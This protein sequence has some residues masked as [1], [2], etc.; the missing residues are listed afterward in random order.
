LCNDL[1]KHFS[2][3]KRGEIR[4]VDRVSFQASGGEILGLLGV[5]GAGKTTTLRVLSTMLKPTS[6]D[7]TLCGFSV[8]N[9]PNE[10]RRRI[11]F[12]STSTGLYGRL[13]AMEMIRYFGKLHGMQEGRIRARTE[14]LFSLFRMNEFSDVRCDKLSSGMKQK[15]S[16]VR[17]VLHDPEVM[18]FDEPTAGLDV[19]TS[20][21]IIDFVLACR[22]RGKCVLLSTHVMEEVE[23][24]CDRA[25]VIH[26]GRLLCCEKVGDLRNRASSGR[27]EDAFVQLV[28]EHKD[29]E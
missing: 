2:D 19:I 8:Q 21:T 6:G 10:V 24:L 26:N 15:V 7:A 14:E 5:N 28:G 3:R 25:A 29:R 16:I 4:A 27:V 23:K 13:T 9:A 17:S 22:A 12:L 18:I 20:R 1:S 11:G